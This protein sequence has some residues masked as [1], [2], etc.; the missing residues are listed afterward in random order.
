[1]FYICIGD[2]MRRVFKTK[3]K[4]NASIIFWL[5]LLF[6]TIIIDIKSFGIVDYS[7]YFNG[8]KIID[9]NIDK[10]KLL[11]KIGFNY[12]LKEALIPVISEVLEVDKPSVYIYNTHQSEEFVDTDIYEVSLMLR[13]MLKDVDIDCYVEETNIAN[14]LKRLNY[15]Y[16]DSYKVTRELLSNNLDKFDLFIDLHRDSSKHNTSTTSIDGKD[17]A[18]VM[19]VIG[20]NHANYELNY[21]LASNLNK[22]IKN[23]DNKLTRGIYVRQSS[24]YNQDLDKNVLLIELGGVEN[25]MEEVSNTLNILVKALEYYFYE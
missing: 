17:Y 23:I 11:S 7:S 2:N 10:D 1:M 25:N 18:R 8:I 22:I 13:D 6:C 19:F 21:G 15:K 16:K 14:E 12:N 5:V 24:T 4:F 20:K 3:K 9:L